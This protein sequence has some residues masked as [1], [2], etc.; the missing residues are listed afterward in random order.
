MVV[1]LWCGGVFVVVSLW[2]RVCCVR[3]NVFFGV[4]VCCCVC[5]CVCVVACLCVCVLMC[6]CVC[7]FFCVCFCT[8]ALCVWGLNFGVCFFVRGRVPVW[9]KSSPYTAHI[10]THI[11]HFL[12]STVFIAFGI[13][14][15]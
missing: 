6:V 8:R 13:S 9:Y 2:L 5:V 1:F 12:Y 7:F 3:R 15:V 4:C 11:K 10:H 14:G